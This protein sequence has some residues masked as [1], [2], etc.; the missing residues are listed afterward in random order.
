MGHITHLGKNIRLM[1]H[2]DQGC[3]IG[4]LQHRSS[5]IINASTLIPEACKLASREV[6][7]EAVWQHWA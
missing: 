6:V 1:R 2:Q 4:N 3:I 5:K 7:Y